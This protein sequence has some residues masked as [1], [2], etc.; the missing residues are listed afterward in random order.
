MDQTVIICPLYCDDLCLCDDDGHR[1]TVMNHHC[2]DD[3]VNDDNQPSS[4]R[5]HGSPVVW[6]TL[7]WVVHCLNILLG[8]DMIFGRVFPFLSSK[9]IITCFPE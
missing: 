6:S 9:Y 5:L 7:Q 3:G 2:D 4:C 8:V 1:Q